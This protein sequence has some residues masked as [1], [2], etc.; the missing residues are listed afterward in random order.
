MARLAAFFAAC[1]IA[2]PAMAS[3]FGDLPRV[4]P[5]FWLALFAAVLFAA[6]KASTKDGETQKT[7][8]NVGIFLLYLIVGGFLSCVLIIVL[9]L[10]TLWKL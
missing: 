7:H 3:N 6:S 9:W 10:A 4:L 8:F 5:F 1:F 2:M